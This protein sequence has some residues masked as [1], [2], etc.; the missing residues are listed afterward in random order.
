MELA[1]LAREKTMEA[2]STAN[3]QAKIDLDKERV[4]MA[5]AQSTIMREMMAMLQQSKSK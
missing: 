2:N 1:K 3:E 4:K 5:T